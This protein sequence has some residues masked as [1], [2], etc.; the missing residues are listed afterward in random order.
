[1]VVSLGILDA[2]QAASSTHRVLVLLVGGVVAG[3]RSLLL[4]RHSPG[5]VSESLWLRG[6]RVPF[7]ASLRAQRALDCDRGAGRFAWPRG[8]A[9]AVWCGRGGLTV[10]EW[11]KLPDWQRRLLVA[12]GAG[13]GMA[14]VYNAWPLGGALFALEVLLG[15]LT[16]PLVLPAL[17]TSLIATGVA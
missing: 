11:A 12:C 8:C 10:S 5:E 15:T 14:A 3:G 17:A 7:W 2:G 13:A 1:M 4:S 6:A 16:L 9:A